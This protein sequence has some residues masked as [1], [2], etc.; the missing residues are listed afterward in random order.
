MRNLRWVFW[1]NF[2]GASTQLNLVLGPN[3]GPQ[4]ERHEPG[5]KKK[6]EKVDAGDDD[7]E[8]DYEMHH[9][10]SENDTAR[11]LQMGASSSKMDKAKGKHWISNE[12]PLFK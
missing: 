8:D 7:S 5:Q 11:S 6:D 3:N 9:R 10:D 12:S 4:G 1:P 2:N